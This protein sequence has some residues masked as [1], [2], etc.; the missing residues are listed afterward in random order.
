MDF[1]GQKNVNIIIVDNGS[2][3][4]SYKHLRKS[5]SNQ[6]N[7]KIIASRENLGFAKGNN[8]GIDSAKKWFDPD[9]IVVMNND[10]YLL[11]NNFN[12]KINS[13]FDKTNFSVLGPKIYLNDG[14]SSSNPMGRK[15]LTNREI[16]ILIIKRIIK[17]TIFKVKLGFLLPKSKNIAERVPNDEQELDIQLHGAILIF[18]RNYF[19]FYNGFYP[20]TFLYFEEYFIYENIKH[21]KLIS[22][23]SPDIKVLHDEDTSTNSLFNQEREK[24]IFVLRNELKSLFKLKR[25]KREQNI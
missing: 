22:V 14:N 11:T 17:L 10:V 7:I 9:F 21:E 24:S 4:N 25:Y 8:F 6:N 16:D 19:K 23:Y 13:I 15:L 1:S 20:E 12:L 18:S 2:N 5:F 3:D